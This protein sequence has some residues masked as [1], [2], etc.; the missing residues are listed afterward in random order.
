MK[1]LLGNDVLE[2]VYYKRKD[3]WYISRNGKETLYDENNVWI[4]FKTEK[5][6]QDHLK[7]VSKQYNYAEIKENNDEN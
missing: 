5:L 4:T 1:L 7:M 6:A 2:P 3:F